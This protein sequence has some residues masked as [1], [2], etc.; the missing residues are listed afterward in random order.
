M[1]EV[2]SSERRGSRV[3]RVLSVLSPG[4]GQVYGGRTLPGFALVL[5]WY[6]VMAGL[7][8][9]RLLHPTAV[10]S[11]LT[12]PWGTVL[13][14]VV[15]AAVWVAANRYRP[16]FDSALPKRRSTRLARAGQR[17]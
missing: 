8:T 17:G 4:T 12:P 10:S 9:S 16:D 15:L 13:A 14:A 5:A 2:Q 1:L 6:A 7:V 11:R 3:F